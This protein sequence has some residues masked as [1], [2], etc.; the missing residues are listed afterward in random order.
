MTE[1]AFYHLLRSPLEAV[2]PKLLEKTRAAD[3]RAVVIA[4][5]G[6]RVDALGALLWS[7]DQDSWLPHGDA[8]DGSPEDQPIWLTETDENPNGAQF[9]FLTDG[10]AAGDLAGFER[11]F[12]L[13]DGRDEVAVADA[14]DRWRALKDAGHTLTYWQQNEQGK[15]EEKSG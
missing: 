5:S 2:L 14:R 13:F 6:E 9:L 11:C 7:Y 3:K 8:K 12:D 4:G 1:I 10:A 15:W